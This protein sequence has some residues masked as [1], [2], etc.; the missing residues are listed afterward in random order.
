MT[1]RFPFTLPPLPNE[2]FGLWWHT[3]ATRLGVTTT[4][5]AR[6]AGLPAG[7]PPGRAHAPTIA[8]AAGLPT[9]QVTATFTTTR[10]CPPASVLRVWTPQPASRFCPHCLTE[11][12][13]QPATPP[14]GWSA[15]WPAA[16]QLPLTFHCLT[17]N[18]P[19]AT[20]CPACHQPPPS[21][22]PHNPAR[23]GTWSCPSCGHNLAG[24]ARRRPP[25]GRTRSATAAAQ[26]RITD[27][28]HRLR[29]PHGTPA[30]RQQ[31]QHELTDITLIA[32][33]LATDLAGHRTGRLAGLPDAAAFTD[34]VRQLAPPRTGADPLAALVARCY[35]GPRI[36]AVPSSWRP[37]SPALT[38]RILH[39]RQSD[40]SPLDRLRHATTLTTPT[41]PDRP[42]ADPAPGRAAGLPDQLWPVWAIRLTDDD[43]ID[44]PFFRSAMTAALLLPLSDLPLGQLT[45]LLPHQPGLEAVGHQLRRLATLPNTDT[46][47]RILTELALALDRHPIPIDYTRRRRL[48]AETTLLDRPTWHALCAGSGLHVGRHRRLDLARCYL[49][50][51][52][53]GGSLT[54]APAPYRLTDATL[55]IDHIEFA[56]AMP[57]PLAAALTEHAEGLLA[58]VGITGEP[59]IWHPPTDWVTVTTW[60]GADPE[61]TD[62]APIHQAVRQRWASTP[63]NHWAPTQAVAAGLGISSQHLREVLRRHPIPAT[64]YRPNRRTLIATPANNGPPH[65]AEDHPDHPRRVFHLD[66]H[67]LREQR[68]TWGRTLQDIAAEIGCTPATLRN[69]ATEQHI[70]PRS[71]NSTASIHTGAAP[72]HPADLPD[73]LRAA[74]RGRAARGRLERF[75]LITD[76]PH[77][78]LTAAA[79]SI[80]AHQSRLTT[81]L[82]RLEHACGG[83]LLQRRPNPQPLGPPTALG[84]QLRRQALRHLDW[85]H[86]HDRTQP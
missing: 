48:T 33:H 24:V 73:L 69:F 13:T 20:S 41:I 4:E 75:L 15:G 7:R 36:P 53:T 83:H 19:L 27:T 17:H 78:S 64:P 84:Q 82:H 40:L 65:R 5:L 70:P 25:A 9:D 76:Q 45:T 56:A 14:A 2:P 74:L 1:G 35:R 72:G 68:T 26:R 11:H 61:T 10:T 3:Y 46:V 16:W 39:S 22:G 23:A 49:Y 81:Q 37:A 38:G 71:R 52:L 28:L 57:G 31:A 60:P 43:S 54:T 30:S 66:P 44:G 80:G 63:H 77:P 59:L 51:L 50:E 8:A 32:A 79:A 12:T 58:T 47:L 67:W 62:P 86:H 42:A 29:D 34:A 85:T 55:R 21:P 18:Q 6:A